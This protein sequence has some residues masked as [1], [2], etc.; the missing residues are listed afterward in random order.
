MAAALFQGTLTGISILLRF[1]L[2]ISIVTLAVYMTRFPS[3]PSPNQNNTPSGSNGTDGAG[4]DCQARRH[5]IEKELNTFFG[6]EKPSEDLRLHLVRGLSLEDSEGQ[7]RREL[8]IGTLVGLERA[9]VA[10]QVNHDPIPWG[11]MQ[12]GR[13]DQEILHKCSAALPPHKRGILIEFAIQHLSWVGYVG[14]TTSQHVEV[15]HHAAQLLDL[16]SPETLRGIPDSNTALMRIRTAIG[17]V[18]DP[19][20]MAIAPGMERDTNQAREQLLNCR[21]PWE[22]LNLFETLH[23]LYEDLRFDIAQLS[24]TSIPLCLGDDPTNVYTDEEDLFDFYDEDDQ[25]SAQQLELRG[26]LESLYTNLLPVLARSSSLRHEVFWD[27]FVATTSLIEPTWNLGLQSLER[28]SQSQYEYRT[29]Q[30][31]DLASGSP[32]G[33]RHLIALCCANRMNDWKP[34][35]SFYKLIARIAPE[36]SDTTKAELVLQIRAVDRDYRS[37]LHEATRIPVPPGIIHQVVSSLCR[38]FDKG[39]KSPQL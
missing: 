31:L 18:L 28:L 4:A 19:N 16:V 24:P 6:G 33:A 17:R 3:S 2:P 15:L 34:T 12:L 1:F 10:G 20:I 35:E 9:V 37:L 27:N 7:D 32:F 30:L 25:F 39:K 13:F 29:R 23:A 14:V 36:L 8:I 38:V 5:T 26:G 21:L 11:V 22:S